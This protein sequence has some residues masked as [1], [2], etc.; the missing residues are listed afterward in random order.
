MNVFQFALLIGAL[1]TLVTARNVK[2]A[3][4]WIFCGGASFIL[5]AAYEAA[6]Y[7]HPPFV[8]MMA[9][10]AIVCLPVYFLAK[11]QWEVWFYRIFAGMVLWSLLFL[12]DLTVGHYWYIVGLEAMNW[13]ALLL[14]NITA[15]LQGARNERPSYQYRLAGVHR[16]GLALWAARADNP[17]HKT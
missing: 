1:L 14:I 2:R 16:I 12:A 4:L 5:S 17:W 15:Y 8:A 11:R 13:A 6:G 7:P 3:D 9:D 10:A